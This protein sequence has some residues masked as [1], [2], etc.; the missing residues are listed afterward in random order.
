MLV[1]SLQ[2]RSLGSDMTAIAPLV[3]VVDDNKSVCRALQRLLESAG[4]KTVTFT[5]P[6]MFLDAPRPGPVS[7]LVLDLRMPEIDGFRLHELLAAEG[8]GIPTIFI[9]AHDNPRNR[10]QAEKA[11]AIAYLMKPFDDE[12]LLE[13]IWSALGEATRTRG[14]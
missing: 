6:Q 4:L 3:Y 5:S 12:T 14:V 13:A 7:C 10:A 8:S 2:L 11:G 1:K 9:T